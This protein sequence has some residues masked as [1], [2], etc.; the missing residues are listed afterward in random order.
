MEKSVKILFAF[1]FIA[2]LL[3]PLVLAR[4]ADEEIKRQK[5]DIK[6][7]EKQIADIKADTTKTAEVKKG[8]L[9]VLEPQLTK[10]REDL[11]KLI[12]ARRDE[13][14]N[15]IKGHFENYWLVVQ[16]LLIPFLLVIL[17]RNYVLLNLAELVDGLIGHGTSFVRTMV[18]F[19]TLGKSWVGF[20]IWFIAMEYVYYQFKDTNF[21]MIGTFMTFVKEKVILSL[22]TEAMI[23]LGVTDITF[24]KV[25]A[26]A[27]L[28]TLLLILLTVG[29]FNII[30]NIVRRIP[31]E[32][33][34]AKAEKMG[35][36]VRVLKETARATAEEMD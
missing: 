32:R 12:T 23:I 18:K 19:V 22:T 11:G 30:N 29:L 27:S 21:L 4:V 16:Y 34:E 25:L 33:R 9:L 15:D 36:D 7:I 1:L 17:I 10:A 28:S 6:A 13:M 5:E 14:K 26:F 35:R 3:A 24:M 2:L 20:G 31:K 8:M